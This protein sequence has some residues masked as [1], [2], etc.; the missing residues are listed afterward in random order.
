VGNT[1]PTLDNEAALAA[2][3]KE[4]DMTVSR[5]N[6]GVSAVENAGEGFVRTPA[7]EVLARAGFVARGLVYGIIGILAFGVALG[8]GGKIT[9][10]QGA[11]HTIARQP[12]GGF[13]LI[14]VAIGLGGYSLWRLFRAA[15]GHGREAVDSGFDRAAALGSGLAYGV[16]C[17]AAVEILTR[18]GGAG[19]A[20]AKHTTAGVLGWPGGTWIVGIFGALMIGVAL[21]QGYRGV[22]QDFL[23][24]SKTEEMGPRMRRWIGRI[25]TVG[26]LARLVVFGL[27]GIFLIKSAIDVSP[28]SAIGLDGALAKLLNR[29]YGSYLL[30]MVAAGL[31]A[32]ALY[33]LSDARFRR[34]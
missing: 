7:F 32:F 1:Y 14:L 22:T 13:L 11:F 28:K 26:Y 8:I 34:I 31:V 33:S 12:F 5:A 15:L 21:Y 24:D 23:K 3:G 17:F 10:Q 18:S 20:N 4:L 6:S 2:R 27:V 29:P 16:M 25:G 9:N 19:T 30:G